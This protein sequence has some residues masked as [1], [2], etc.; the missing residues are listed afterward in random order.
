MIHGLLG[1]DDTQALPFECTRPE[2]G[3]HFMLHVAACVMH[4]QLL[5]SDASR[6]L[7]CPASQEARVDVDVWPAWHRLHTDISVCVHY[8]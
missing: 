5:G 7:P 3:S 6:S 2:K 8:T 4:S 1:T